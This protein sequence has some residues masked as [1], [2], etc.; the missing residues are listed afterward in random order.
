MTLCFVYFISNLIYTSAQALYLYMYLYKRNVVTYK[1]SYLKML[2]PG[3]GVLE[4]SLS[5][6][7]G[8]TEVRV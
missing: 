8:Q 4:I 1:R 7:E 6:L 5:S 3:Y 2:I